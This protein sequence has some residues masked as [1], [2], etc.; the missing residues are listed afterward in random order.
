MKEVF[1]FQNTIILRV[2][3]LL[4]EKYTKKINTWHGS[5][6]NIGVDEDEWKRPP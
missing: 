1:G 5:C 3:A 4:R 6:C 2:S